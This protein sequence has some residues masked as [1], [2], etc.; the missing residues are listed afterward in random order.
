MAK[1]KFTARWIES[2]TTDVSQ[3][4]YYDTGTRIRGMSFGLRVSRAGAKSFFISYR[5]KGGKQKHFTI[6]DAS[7]MSLADARAIAVAKR[8]G[9]DK[10]QDPA[11]EKQAYKVAT[12]FKELLEQFGRHFKAQVESGE[13]RAGTWYEYENSFKHYLSKWNDYKVCEIRRADIMSLLDYIEVERKAPV[14]AVRVR[15]QIH[16]IMS[17]A[18]ERSIIENHPCTGL[19]RLRKANPRTRYLSQEEVC[20]VW[21]ALDDFPPPSRNAIKMML[22]TGQRKGE[23]ANM[24]WHEISGDDWQLPAS[25]VKSKRDHI[26]PLS[27]QALAILEE[28]KADTEEAKKTSRKKGDNAKDYYDYF[29]FP[30]RRQGKPNYCFNHTIRRLY[31]IA[32][33]KKFSPHDFRRTIG[34]HLSS[35]GFT[36][37]VISK[38]LNHKS[39]TVTGKHYVH[40][41]ALMEKRVALEKWGEMV[42][43]WVTKAR[44]EQGQASPIVT[45]KKSLEER[46]IECQEQRQKLEATIH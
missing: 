21:L 15:S 18:I 35:L 26:V 24:A 5:N 22:L 4:E 1:E 46:F 44:Q 34:T 31:A 40:Y 13:R 29:V 11:E 12:T 10:G 33:V 20:K 36:E 41:A 9:L 43:S 6:G 8:T 28:M 37:G 17:F 38:V 14:Q 2:I 42:E 7:R 3:A 19:P 27:K 32:G 39:D 30:S 45:T 25:R 23:V 16:R